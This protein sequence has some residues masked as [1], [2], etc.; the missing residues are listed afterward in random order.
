MLK[1]SYEVRSCI[2]VEEDTQNR[3]KVATSLIW[4]LMEEACRVIS[5]AQIEETRDWGKVEKP[6]SR[7]INLGQVL[8]RL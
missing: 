8:T 7:I 4:G 5:Q 3:R 1:L 2:V 6:D